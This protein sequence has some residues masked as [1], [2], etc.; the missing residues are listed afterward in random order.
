MH[1]GIFLVNRCLLRHIKARL[2]HSLWHYQRLT[3]DDQQLA[4]TP[5]TQSTMVKVE[6]TWPISSNAITTTAAPN[7]FMI[8]AFSRKSFSPSFRLIELTMHLP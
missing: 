3:R 6:C 4:I 8:F 1:T 7:L 2:R 5:Q